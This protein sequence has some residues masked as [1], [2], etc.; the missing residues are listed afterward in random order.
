M[1]DPRVVL[2]RWQSDL[3]ALARRSRETPGILFVATNNSLLARDGCVVKVR[4][5]LRIVMLALAARPQMCVTSDHLAEMLWG[6]DPDGGPLYAATAIGV[7]VGE[8]RDAFAVL[9]YHCKTMHGRG[10][11]VWPVLTKEVEAA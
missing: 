3:D 7:L 2:I 8:A 4:A 6:D 1:L 10:Y 9:G 5:K 11:T